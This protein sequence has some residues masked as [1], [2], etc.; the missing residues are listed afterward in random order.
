ERQVRRGGDVD[1]HAIESI[2]QQAKHMRRL[3]ED[4]LDDV[5]ERGQYT[6]ERNAIDLLALAQDVASQAPASHQSL[7]VEGTSVIAEVDEARMR[8]VLTNLVENAVKYSPGGRP[9]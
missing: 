5:R 4:L 2:V 9:I 1:A 3:V 7:T 8:Q 6:S